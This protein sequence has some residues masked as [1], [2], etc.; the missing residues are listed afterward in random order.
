V[1]STLI[2]EGCARSSRDEGHQV[3]ARATSSSGRTSTHPAAT[4]R[5]VAT[6]SRAAAARRPSSRGRRG[7]GDPLIPRRSSAGRSTSW[8]PARLSTAPR[9][10]TAP[11]R[12]RRRRSTTRRTCR[13]R[14]SGLT[15]SA[16]RYH[17][18]RQVHERIR[19][20]PDYSADATFTTTGVDLGL[21]GDHDHLRRRRDRR[22]RAA[23]VPVGH[24]GLD[25]GDATRRVSNAC[26]LTPAG[27]A[28]Q[29][30][31]GTR[32]APCCSSARASGC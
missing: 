8:P 1:T 16:P 3:E 18:P 7:R 28:K 25:V 9:R 10:P 24:H 11:P 15:T 19:Q 12:P 31:R 30:W 5:S 26:R 4:R 22:R 17:L 27:Y 32:T 23:G 2:V 6:T 13:T 29:T 21:P 20:V 14:V